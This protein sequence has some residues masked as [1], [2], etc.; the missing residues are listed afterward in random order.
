MS[1]SLRRLAGTNADAVLL[2]AED[3]NKLKM[4]LATRMAAEGAVVAAA[5]AEAVNERLTWRVR[6]EGRTRRLLERCRF[7][8]RLWMRQ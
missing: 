4:A 3:E 7:L 1:A 5:E 2:V 8:R 6:M